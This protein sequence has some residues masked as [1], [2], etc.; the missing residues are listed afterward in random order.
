MG[1]EFEPT[2]LRQLYDGLAALK[3]QEQ[4]A[5]AENHA[6][7]PELLLHRLAHDVE[8]V[9]EYDDLVEPFHDEGKRVGL[10]DPP[11]LADLKSTDD[12]AAHLANEQLW[13]VAGG[14]ELAF[15]FV[16]R[17]IFPLRSTR[18]DGPR[19]A[20]RSLDVLLASGDGLP[21]VGEL[22]IRQ[23]KPTYYAFIQAL[24][25]AA[26]LS[27]PPQRDRLASLY[28][29][30]EFRWPAGGPFLDLYVIAFEP[31]IR[32]KYRQRSYEA[33]EKISEQM[34]GDPRCASVIRRIAYIEASAE[35]D[36]LTFKQS[37]A[38]SAGA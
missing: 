5:L 19:A 3:E 16:D 10:V 2:Q 35:R 22:K 34:V 30:A 21:I 25:Y 11:P 37:F 8:T 26:E 17:E 13:P 7:D 29:E 31:P 6:E 23:D 4:T 18:K 27:S 9:A 12:F 24:M 15:R 36:Q 20:R 32:G 33:V 28:R 38:F 14:E 1:S